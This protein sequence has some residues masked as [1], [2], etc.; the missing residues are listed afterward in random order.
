MSLENGDS[1]IAS[2]T[3]AFKADHALE[4]IIE[5]HILMFGPD[6]QEFRYQ[7]LKAYRGFRETHPEIYQLSA[8]LIP[9]NKDEWLRRNEAFSKYLKDYK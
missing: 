6:A 3:I 9:E 1:R 4:A 5:G 8:N 2:A 7:V